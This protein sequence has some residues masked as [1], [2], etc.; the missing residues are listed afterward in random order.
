MSFTY[1]AIRNMNVK[2]FILA[3]TL[4][5]TL[6]F[7]APS[8]RYNNSTQCSSQNVISSTVQACHVSRPTLAF[9]FLPPEV[10]EL[11]NAFNKNN[12]PPETPPESNKPG[13]YKVFISE[14]LFPVAKSVTTAA[15][16][17]LGTFIFRPITGG[18][19]GKATAAISP[20]HP[21]LQA[22]GDTTLH[23][24][25]VSTG[26][27]PLTTH[28]VKRFIGTAAEQGLLPFFR[29]YPSHLLSY[30]LGT[31][32][33]WS[34]A[35]ITLKVGGRLLSSSC[36]TPDTK[37]YERVLHSL[38][39]CVEAEKNATNF[40]TT[41]NL[42]LLQCVD[43]ASVRASRITRLES[44]VFERQQQ[45]INMQSNSSLLSTEL[46]V[47]K[48]RN[49]HLV[50]DLNNCRSSLET[51]SDNL[52]R[53]DVLNHKLLYGSPYQSQDTHSVQQALT[54]YEPKAF[55]TSRSAAQSPASADLFFIK[56]GCSLGVTTTHL[57]GTDYYEGRA[58]CR[59][60]YD[61]GNMVLTLL[62]SS[63]LLQC[64]YSGYIRYTD[65]L[66]KAATNAAR[67]AALENRLLIQPH[68]VIS[69]TRNTV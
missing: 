52:R 11:M 25:A 47:L 60:V 27:A 46:A 38:S 16:G 29:S 31:A 32:T 58:A 26:N 62:V 8:S 7:E 24:T 40:A 33:G 34:M 45:M 64:T 2:T 12:K 43:L 19:W 17:A 50:Q 48:E 66:H 36:P 65:Y 1:L 56:G 4:A 23:T 61:L 55:T 3:C 9:F 39:D 10:I 59:T 18:V 51:T 37:Q 21:V 28:V 54:I 67:L 22:I 63:G 20:Q 6:R 30:S 13:W 44:D 41:N 5:S 14:T 53:A 42:H 68:N 35:E 57:G 49:S 15:A 69:V